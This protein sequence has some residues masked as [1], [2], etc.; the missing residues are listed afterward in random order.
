MREAAKQDWEMLIVSEVTAA[1]SPCLFFIVPCSRTRPQSNLPLGAGLGAG[2]G[3]GAL[4]TCGS[5]QWD[6]LDLTGF[7]R[8]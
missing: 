5:H 1:P 4:A 6:W 3:V 8:F 2:D 7:K